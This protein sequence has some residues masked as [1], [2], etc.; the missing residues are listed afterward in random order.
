MDI[1]EPDIANS[2]VPGTPITIPSDPVVLQSTPLNYTPLPRRARK[3]IQPPP[4]LFDPS[5]KQEAPYN[6]SI[7]ITP[8]IDD[9]R[10]ERTFSKT[11]DINSTIRDDFDDLRAFLY[12]KYIKE[13]ETIRNLRAHEK[14][15]LSH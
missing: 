14:P 8:V 4:P 6:M 11:M 7:F 1:P 15:K 10:K 9:I 13:F 5:I 2:P 12:T 3:A